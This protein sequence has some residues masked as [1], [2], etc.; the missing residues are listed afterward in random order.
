MK[1]IA[2]VNWTDNGQENNKDFYDMLTLSR[3]V[4]SLNR[5]NLVN[6]TCMLN[7]NANIP[8]REPRSHREAI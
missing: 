4:C 2:V 1:P 7:I 8:T 3:F 6:V 5:R